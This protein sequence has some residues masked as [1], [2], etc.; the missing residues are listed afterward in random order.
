MPSSRHPHPGCDGDSAFHA[1]SFLLPCLGLAG[2]IFSLGFLS[3]IRGR[4]RSVHSPPSLRSRTSC[5]RA[6][7][8]KYSSL[9]Q[10]H[11]ASVT[12]N[13][14][15]TTL[16]IHHPSS[17]ASSDVPFLSPFAL[18]KLRPFHALAF[19]L[20][21]RVRITETHRSTFRPQDARAASDCFYSWTR[22]ICISW[23]RR[24]CRHEWLSLAR[25]DILRMRGPSLDA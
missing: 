14:V 9:A 11:L 5:P 25:R 8:F 3:P 4:Q 20:Q 6:L 10:E 21:R 1:Y 17:Q 15:G 2:C 13:V 22:C 24:R 12:H 23:T 16:D 7:Y 18:P 19:P